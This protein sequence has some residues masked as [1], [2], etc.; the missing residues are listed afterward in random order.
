LA[1]QEESKKM[2]LV[3]WQPRRDLLWNTHREASRLFDEIMTRPLHGFSLD[4]TWMPQ[5]DIEERSDEYEVT[6]DIPGI[7]RKDLNVTVKEQLLVVEGERKQERSE[8]EGNCH[9]TERRYGT[10][11][12]SFRLPRSADGGRIRAAY[13]NGVLRISIPKSEDAKPREIEIAV[14]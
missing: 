13:D 1:T 11:K 4:R 8:E 3:R 12:R 10:F 9:L 14:K 2:T 5:A 6:M 7:D